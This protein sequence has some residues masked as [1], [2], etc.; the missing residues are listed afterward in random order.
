MFS[1][2]LKSLLITQVFICCGFNTALTLEQQFQ[3]FINLDRHRIAKSTEI[4]LQNSKVIVSPTDGGGTIKISGNL[5]EFNETLL[6]FAKLFKKANKITPGLEPILLYYTFAIDGVQNATVIQSIVDL[7]TLYMEPFLI[8]EGITDQ[9]KYNDA[10]KDRLQLI[11]GLCDKY[12][13]FFKSL[14]NLHSSI[15]RNLML[16]LINSQVETTEGASRFTRGDRGGI[17]TFPQSITECS[18]NI[19]VKFEGLVDVHPVVLKH[20]KIE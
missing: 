6:C 20:G 9:K 17:Y 2:I 19:R 5:A 7:T 3:D 15:Y 18:R 16:P 1:E 14:C 4:A 13:G 12:A 11:A 8:Y 10:L